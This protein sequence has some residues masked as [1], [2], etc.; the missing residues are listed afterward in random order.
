MSIQFPQKRTVI[1]SKDPDATAR[2]LYEEVPDSY[3]VL[4]DPTSQLTNLR[5]TVIEEVCFGLEQRGIDVV[6][7]VTR[8]KEVMDRLNISAIAEMNPSKLSAGQTKRV[9]LAGVAVQLEGTLILDDPFTGLNEVAMNHVRRLLYDYPGKTIVVL[10]NPRPFDL[11]GTWMEERDG[12][13]IEEKNDI[14]VPIPEPVE[15]QEAPPLLDATIQASRPSPP[16]KWWQF[17][18]KDVPEFTSAPVRVVVNPGE[19][20]WLSGPNGTG[21]S[22]VLRGLAGLDQNT[23]V[24][25]YALALQRAQDQVVNSTMRAYVGNDELLAQLGIGPEAHPLDLPRAQL[26]LAQVGGVLNGERDIVALDKPDA[27]LGTETRG[28]FYQL[29]AQALRSGKGVIMTCH[30]REVMSEIEQF[31]HVRRI[32]MALTDAE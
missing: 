28:T 4:G 7:M 24:D 17:T 6:T 3:L 25:N 23:G 9:A 20:T 5:D 14:A 29:L 22:T 32:E 2:R 8:A 13:F 18:A 10:S 19:V 16:R 30:N 21:K 27:D 15:P 1:V 26:R 11:R 31:A 12:E